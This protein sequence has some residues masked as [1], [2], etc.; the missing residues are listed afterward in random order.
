[1]MNSL[2]DDNPFARQHLKDISLLSGEDHKETLKDIKRLLNFSRQKNNCRSILINGDRGTGKTSL[3]K[4][5][6]LDAGNFNCLA[7]PYFLSDN[8]EDKT[9]EFFYELY[10]LLFKRCLESEVLIEEIVATETAVA[11]G[12]LPDDQRKWVFRF[13]QKYLEYKIHSDRPSNLMAEDICADFELIIGQFRRKVEFGENAKITILIDEAQRIFKNSK[14]LNIIRHLIQEEIGVTFIL[15]SQLVY[16]DG[17]IR[18]VFDRLERAFKVYELK[19][20]SSDQDVKEFIDKSLK[21]VGWK[22]KDLRLNIQKFDTIVSSIYHLTNGKPEFINGILE[23]MF[24]RVQNGIDRKLRLN[25]QVL[26]EIAGQIESSSPDSKDYRGFSFNLSRAK[27]IVS[28]KGDR[29]KWFRYLS[30]S[31]FRSTPNEVYEFMH[32]FTY[33][34]TATKEQFHRFVHELNTKEILFPIDPSEKNTAEL[35]F[36]ITRNESKSPFDAPYIYFGNTSEKVWTNL[37]LGLRKSSIM[38]GFQHPADSFIEEVM[39]TAGFHGKRSLSVKSKGGLVLNKDGVWHEEGQ[40]WDIQG[41]ME[42]LRDGA[43]NIEDYDLQLV[44]YLFNI[45]K[46][47]HHSIFV[48]AVNVK[49]SDTSRTRIAYQEE[50]FSEARLEDLSKIVERVN[51]ESRVISFQLV[52]I[53]K[54][55]LL[56]KEEFSDLIR[57]SDNVAAKRV[58]YIESVQPASELY[59]DDPEANREDILQW[60]DCVYEGVVAGDDISFTELNNSGYMFL[61]LSENE[62]ALTCF[63]RAYNELKKRGINDPEL[64]D[65]TAVLIVYNFAIIKVLLNQREEASDL[66]HEAISISELVS[67]WDI[68]AL[69]VLFKNQDGTIELSETQEK[70]IDLVALATSNLDLLNGI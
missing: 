60:L 68:G 45:F 11:R 25:D 41:F 46:S 54:D 9:I 57:A 5:I 38:F 17:V 28:L 22:D 1:M 33:D 29:L 20:F 39:F 12:E 26:D 36:K 61:N 6:E 69:N 31:I 70:N 4:L 34:E 40:S 65:S 55:I 67:D 7:V 53:T 23:R 59:M 63:H 66:F 52:E 51:D 24:D 49:F 35:G 27:Y 50:T 64:S 48:C 3:I 18:H 19:H 10:S 32:P 15:A 8:Y 37:M 13:M 16:E 58:I 43:S 30:K 62:K 21:S 2:F 47:N 42:G 14:I 56:S 44:R